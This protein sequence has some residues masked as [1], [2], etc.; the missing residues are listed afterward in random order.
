MGSST[1]QSF[2][3]KVSYTF[4]LKRIGGMEISVEVVERRRWLW[5]KKEKLK[6]K[7]VREDEEAN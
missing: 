2:I 4:P 7:E 5:R 1:L 3:C 6:R